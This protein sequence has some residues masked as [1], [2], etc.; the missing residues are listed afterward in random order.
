VAFDP[1]PSE[2]TELGPTEVPLETFDSLDSGDVLFVDTTHT[3]KTGGD[4]PHL[5]SHVVPSLPPGVLVH[6]HDIF[7]PYEYPKVGDRQAACLG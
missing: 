7:L 5:F 6:F 2:A 4:V 3:V 1:Y